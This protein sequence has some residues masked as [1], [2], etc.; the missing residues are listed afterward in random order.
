PPLTSPT[1]QSED[2]PKKKR[3]RVPILKKKPHKGRWVGLLSLV[4]LAI[5]LLVWYCIASI[6]EEWWFSTA[7]TYL[8]RAP[9]LLPAVILLVC[10]VVIHR[11]SI[12]FNV[13][14]IIIVL[15]LIMEFNIPSGAVAGF[16]KRENLVIVSCNI[17]DYE[18]NFRKVLNEIIRQDP[19]VI[20]FQEAR[21]IHPAFLEQYPDWHSLVVEQF[22]VC[23]RYPIKKIGTCES[24]AFQRVTALAVEIETPQGTIRLVNTHLM[25]ARKGLIELSLGAIFSG[26]GPEEVEHFQ[27]TREE[28]ASD[29]WLFVSGISSESPLIIVGD[30]NMP[31]SSSIYEKNWSGYTNAFLATNWGYGYT[32]PCKSHR[33]WLEDTPWLRIDHILT[34]AH[35]QVHSCDIGK[36]NG[37]DHRFIS[38]RI[39]LRD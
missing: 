24:R 29:T 36:T 7:L 26:E 35:W 23:S 6:S 38:A 16:S 22:V 28:E 9:W 10:S 31:S 34:N 12:P 13:V 4:Y 27:R 39:S 30:F 19:D 17:Q 8:P 11:K 3:K 5:I 14:S 1:Q 2:P 33:L 15:W 18:P 20:A 25:T 37:S 21:R 32:S